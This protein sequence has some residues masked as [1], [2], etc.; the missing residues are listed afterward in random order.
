MT[1]TQNRHGSAYDRG[2]ADAY[3]RRPPRPHYF[4]GNSFSSPIV[5]EE[6]MTEEEI[7]EYWRGYHEGIELGDFKEW[8]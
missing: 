2:S 5:T 7:K 8:D 3:Y 6:H 1:A 4:E